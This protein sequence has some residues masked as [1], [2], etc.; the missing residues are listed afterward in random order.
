[1]TGWV[2]AQIRVGPT[3]VRQVFG[4]GPIPDFWKVLPPRG[5]LIGQGLTQ[6]L[7]NS[8]LLKSVSDGGESTKA[9]PFPTHS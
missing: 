9:L 7:G 4:A 2:Q 6:I 3:P 1:M 8:L 5:G